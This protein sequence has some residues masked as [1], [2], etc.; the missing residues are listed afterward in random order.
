MQ[1]ERWQRLQEL[2]HAAS[3][4]DPAERTAFLAAV[5]PDDEELRRQALS[6][7]MAVEAEND[8]IA[9]WVAAGAANMQQ[10]L[11]PEPGARIGPYQVE[12]AIGAG[13]MGSV[14]L[15]SRA[16]DQFRKQV[17]I[18]LMSRGLATPE[19][20]RRFRA[21]RQILATLD[22]P[23]VARLLDG[24]VSGAGVPYVV[25]EYV[26][27]LAIDEYCDRHQLS[28]N[29]RLGL[30]RAVCDAVQYAHRNLIVHR[31]IKPGNI[32]VT[33]DGIPKLLDFGI[34]KIL[35]PEAAQVTVAVTRAVERL[36]TPEYASPEQVLGETIT[37]ASDVYSLGVLLYRLLSGRQPF[38]LTDQSPA[39]WERLLC[40]AEPDLPSQAARSLGNLQAARALSGDL[41]TIILMA[42]RKEPARRYASVEQLSEDIRRHLDGFPVIAR[43]DTFR[44]RSGKFLRR[45]KGTV[46]LGAA[47]F[48]V[49]VGFAISM[50]VVN[51]RVAA[52][53]DVANR[54]RQQAELVSKFLTD[55]FEV[56]DPQKTPANTITAREILDKGAQRIS[57]DLKSQPR[58]QAKLLGVMGKVYENIGD[59][60][61]S[62]SLLE[63][64]LAITRKVFADSEP[65]FGESLKD[66]SEL[67]RRRNDL[68]RAEALIRESV[69]LRRRFLGPDHPETVESRNTL[70]LVLHARGNWKEAESIFRELLERR[71][72]L[73]QR[74]FLETAVL[75]N[76]GA[77]L[78]DEGKFR[79]AEQFLNECVDIRRRTLGNNHPRLGL[80]LGKLARTYL[81]D[82][83]YDEAE[84]AARESLA[85]RE[86]SLGP[87]GGDV[88]PALSV[89]GA[90][91]SEL[92]QPD[93]AALLERAIEIRK[94]TLGPDTPEEA[95]DLLRLAWIHELAGDRNGADRRLEQSFA[96]R[97]GSAPG[98]P[99]LRRW[100]HTKARIALHRGDLASAREA[101]RA[102]L[103]SSSKLPAPHPDYAE[104][105]L[106]NARIEDANHDG[107]RAQAG[108]REALTIYRKTVS[109]THHGLQEAQAALRPGSTH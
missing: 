21:E 74:E 7:V 41:D 1:S 97:G 28:I 56:A 103:E 9:G 65:E 47:L 77:V 2:F 55:L 63:E 8:S 50:A 12:R 72:L 34:A 4:V 86:R 58:I 84:A 26:D 93:A 19:L 95:A 62:R 69:E 60:E 22:H 48:L 42:L 17:A 94:R 71:D 85:I 105:L 67:A 20:V 23:N 54:E 39:A 102:A 92:N 15:A 108:Y 32:L 44:Y 6:L 68:V 82:G 66:L 52:E 76:I 87:N 14:Y 46:L 91:R 33:A 88:A 57:R 81:Q 40:E 16:D 25:M 10:S 96:G 53:R 107:A 61:R 83:R 38:V 49:V 36:L 27:G 64:R 98:S 78:T 31:D 70:A 35:K 5:C 59:Y 109:A 37:T 79:D 3:D 90:I 18:K 11:E 99:A 51:K 30:F 101:I 29:E 75:S 73:R 13:G 24:G 89:L 80:V 45:N 43:R 100:R 104:D 106:L